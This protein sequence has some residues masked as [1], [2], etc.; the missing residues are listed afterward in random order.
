MAREDIGQLK[1]VDT[2]TEHLEGQGINQPSQ[3]EKDSVRLDSLTSLGHGT[4]NDD[5][6]SY[7][8]PDSQ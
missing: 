1:G 8:K 3:N 4:C 7:S 6:D 2:D 5:E